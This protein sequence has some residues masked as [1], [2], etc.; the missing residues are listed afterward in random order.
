MK[1]SDLNTNLE[2]LDIDYSDFQVHFSRDVEFLLKVT[3]KNFN[4]GS[5]GSRV[6]FGQFLHLT[7]T[8]TLQ[9]HEINLKNFDI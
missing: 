9:G 5:C 6:C 8:L 3:V 1:N 4:F 2:V 7:L